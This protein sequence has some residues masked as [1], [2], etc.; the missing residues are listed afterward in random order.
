VFRKTLDQ[1]VECLQEHPKKG[2]GW[3]S[4][5]DSELVAKNKGVITELPTYRYRRRD[6]GVL[7][8]GRWPQGLAGDAE[9]V[10]S[11]A[12]VVS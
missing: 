3:L 1:L 7:N 6:Y 11:T 9:T 4:L 5:S 2:V 10:T 8:T 12:F